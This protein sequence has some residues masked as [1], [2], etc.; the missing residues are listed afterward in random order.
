MDQIKIGKFIQSLRKEKNLTQAELAKIIGVSD[1]TISKWENGRGLPDYE[2]IQDL[3]NELAITFNEFMAGEK[4][5]AENKEIKLE[6]NLISAYNDT[7]KVNKKLSLFKTCL[8][9]IIVIMIIITGMFIIDAHQM[10]NNKP[11]IFST[12]GLKYAPPYDLNELELE[13]TIKDFINTKQQEQIKKR[14]LVKGKGFS[15]INTFLI[16]ENKNKTEYSVSCWILEEIFCEKDSE[17]V[18]ESGSS[19]AYKFIIS[20]SADDIY[21]V[22]SYQIP[23]DGNRYEDSLKEIFSSSVRRQIADFERYNEV[24]KLKFKIEQDKDNYYG[25]NQ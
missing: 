22:E 19:I 2:Y 8:L 20:R 16:E 6:E 11:V 3:C 18:K 5:K 15:E 12:W 24:S 13:K 1:R 7:R 10:K 25:D 14:C 9:S 17:I 4:I 21:K 23:K